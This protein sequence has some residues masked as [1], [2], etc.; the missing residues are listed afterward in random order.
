MSFG[1]KTMAGE[2][3]HTTNWAREIPA[4]NKPMGRH[5]QYGM[6]MILATLCKHKLDLI[7][8]S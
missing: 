5:V 3:E 8:R 1:N 6:T 4:G 2:V 7:A